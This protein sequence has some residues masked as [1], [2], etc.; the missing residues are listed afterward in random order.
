MIQ[1]PVTSPDLPL[2][3]HLATLATS[4][5]AGSSR[6]QGA[7]TSRC[8]LGSPTRSSFSV[9]SVVPCPVFYGCF[10]LPVSS[11]LPLSAPLARTSSY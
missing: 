7:G 10:C 3:Q 6:A 5:G 2:Q 9:T 11:K 1:K 8:F 4:V